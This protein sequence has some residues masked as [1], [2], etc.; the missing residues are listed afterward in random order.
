[1]WCQ[2]D[3]KWAKKKSLSIKTDQKWL[4]VSKMGQKLVKMSQNKVLMLFDAF[5]RVL[6]CSDAFWHVP[7]CFDVF[8][9]VLMYPDGF[10]IFCL[11]IRYIYL[12]LDFGVQWYQCYA[13]KAFIRAFCDLSHKN[14]SPDH[15]LHHSFI[16][17]T[18]FFLQRTRLSAEKVFR[19]LVWA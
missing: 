3:D 10:T 16:N 7:T 19:A 8:W 17:S 6:T 12:K 2:I 15:I 13:Q 11:Y 4:K 5:R 9:W 18:S 1:M 14:C